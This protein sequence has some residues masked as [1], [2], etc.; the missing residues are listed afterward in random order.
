L[1]GEALFGGVGLEGFEGGLDGVGVSGQALGSREFG[2][3]VAVC[4]RDIEAANTLPLKPNTKRPVLSL[5][6][7][8][9]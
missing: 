9:Y 6:L 5:G 2:Q 4:L 8:V 3:F 1:D 7:K